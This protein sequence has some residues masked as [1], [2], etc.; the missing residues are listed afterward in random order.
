[1]NIHQE[2]DIEYQDEGPWRSYAFSTYGET[3]EELIENVSVLETDQ[4][5]G[6]LDC[7]SFENSSNKIQDM[8]EKL[9]KEKL[10]EKSN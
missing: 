1:M 10:N 6:E 9:I 2:L 8:I 3:Y 5:G 4:D 7:Y